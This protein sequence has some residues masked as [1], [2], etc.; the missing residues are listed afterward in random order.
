MSYQ[1]LEKQVI[2]KKADQHLC[3][4][5][6]VTTHN[7]I[8]LID[9]ATSKSDLMFEGLTSGKKAC[10]LLEKALVKAAPNL[11][12]FA[13]VDVMTNAIYEFYQKHQLTQR[14]E[15]QPHDR[16]TAAIAVYSVFHQEV[17]LIGDTQ[18]LI[19]QQCYTNEKLIDQ[20]IANARALYLEMALARGEKISD[21]LENDQGRQFVLPLLKH[22]SI[23]Q[24]SHISSKYAY[25]VIDGFP[26]KP[27]HLLIISVNHPIIILASDG[28]PKLFP[29]LQQSEDYL[30]K[31]LKQDPL[32]YQSLRSTK[33]LAAGQASFDDRSWVK[34][35]ID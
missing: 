14:M 22:Q 23:Y 10:D 9:G 3:E 27:E 25:G 19:N 13:F 11:D 15:T 24:N 16:I 8:M 7:Y 35:K 29:N 32:C 33:C 2:G 26:P 21:L 28:Y 5:H 1:I 31:Q 34:F 20:D 18:C 4:D 12:A 30:T 6:I 17:W